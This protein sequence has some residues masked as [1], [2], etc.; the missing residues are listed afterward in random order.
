[1]LSQIERIKIKLSLA[2][3]IDRNYEVFGASNHQ[4]FLGQT[5]SE[6]DVLKFENDYDISLPESYREFLLHIGNGGISYNN[7]AAGPYYGIFRLGENLN[8]YISNNIVNCLKS[9]CKIYPEMS[10]EF[11]KE[12]TIKIDNDDAISDEDFDVE[13]GKIFSGILPIGTQGC[14]YYNGLVLNGKHKG[15][16]VCIDIDMQKPYFLFEPN[17]LDWYERWLDEITAD[18]STENENLFNFTLGGSAKYILKVFESA[19]DRETKLE[20]LSGIL[21][22]KKVVLDILDVLEKE[23]KCNDIDIQ[24]NIL[25]ILTKFDYNRAYSY[26]NDLVEKDLLTVFQFVLWYAKDKSMD[27]LKIITENISKIDDDETF[28]F[29]TYLLMEMNIDYGYIL[30]PYAS[31]SNEKIRV[32]AYYSLGK[33]KNKEKYIENFIMGLN[34]KAN[35][36]IHTTLQALDDIKDERLLQHYKNIAIRFPKEKDYILVNLNHRLKDY[37][38]T[39]ETILYSNLE[40]PAS[41]SVNKKWFKFWK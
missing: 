31:H 36:V 18:T 2:K 40:I 41:N 7:S 3:E 29:C 39:N 16:I 19:K 23:I 4:Y 38:L 34:D 13:V 30:A 11:W 12:M 17:F 32:S 37:N 9:D 33:L 1:V 5:V 27:W 21:K 15:K 20:C 24:K 10:E 14:T 26:L 8:E 35:R 28:R 22:K 25:Q 6:Q